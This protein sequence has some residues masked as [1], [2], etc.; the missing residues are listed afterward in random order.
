MTHNF[1]A[2]DLAVKSLGPCRIDS[3]L[4][5]LLDQRERTFHNVH[6]EDRVLFDDT[7]SSLI[8]RN[9]PADQL[10][11]QLPAFEP[12][13]PRRKSFSIRPRPAPRS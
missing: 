4:I 1:T 12:A 9:L 5:P 8:E 2:A 11:S 10:V 3:P 13:G 7:L 6:E